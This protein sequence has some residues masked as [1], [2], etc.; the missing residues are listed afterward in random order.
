MSRNV[1]KTLPEAWPEGSV[2]SE[3]EVEV[4]LDDCWAASANLGAKIAGNPL[5]SATANDRHVMVQTRP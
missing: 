4:V 3:Q 5:P 2:A 1:P